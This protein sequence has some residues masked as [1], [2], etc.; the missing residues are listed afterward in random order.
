MSAVIHTFPATRPESTQP[1]TD[2]LVD[3]L[4]RAVGGRRN[5]RDDDADPAVVGTPEGPRPL[6][7]IRP[8][9]AGGSNDLVVVGVA[10]ADARRR[11]LVVAAV[12]LAIAVMF[13]LFAG[14]G[15]AVADGEVE[16]AQV[17]TL[18]AGET[19]WQLADEITPPGQDVRPTLRAIMTL[20]GFESASLPAGTPV[21]LPSVQD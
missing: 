2:E 19:L 15:G 16:V 11:R 9:R 13:A 12:T 17:T 5:R 8:D 7:A 20:N 4:A 10:P 18:Q 14:L 1:D 6:V 21:K 3:D